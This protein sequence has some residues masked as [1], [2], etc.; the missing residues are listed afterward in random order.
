MPK[1]ALS[2]PANTI[3]ELEQWGQ[4]TA[5][6]FQRLRAESGTIPPNTPPSQ[7]W[8]WSTEWQVGE[9]QADHEIATGQVAIFEDVNDL[10][11]DLN[12]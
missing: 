10:L 1:T 4:R 7:A 8:F 3:F 2:L 11:A 12:V 5:D 6:L 9:H